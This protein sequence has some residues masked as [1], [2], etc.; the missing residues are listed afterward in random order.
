[1]LA[2]DRVI[3]LEY[4][5]VVRVEPAAGVIGVVVGDRVP[6]VISVPG[7]VA[8]SPAI[9]NRNEM[10]R[11]LELL[12]QDARATG[13]PHGWFHRD[14]EK[15][16]CRKQGLRRARRRSGVDRTRKQARPR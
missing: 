14:V 5:L 15:R 4:V 11:F 9:F 13:E 2:D 8:Q 3:A 1:M 7:G 10:V 12:R 16:L 6:L